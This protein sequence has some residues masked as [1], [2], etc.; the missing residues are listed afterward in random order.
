MAAARS[1]LGKTTA[2]TKTTPQMVQIDTVT[3]YQANA[4]IEARFRILYSNSFLA[5]PVRSRGS[6]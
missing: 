5:A 4:L 3:P 6:N 1:V 2:T